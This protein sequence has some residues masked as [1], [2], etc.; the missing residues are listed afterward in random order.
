[1]DQEHP[2]S[3]LQES[4]GA[5]FPSTGTLEDRGRTWRKAS[6]EY[7]IGFVMESWGTDAANQTSAVVEMQR[8]LMVSIQAASDSAETQTAEVIKLT[9]ALKAYTIVLA[10]IGVVQIALIWLKG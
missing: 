5:A 6:D 3:K 1:M 4:K 9:R 8:R 10:M 2:F 7:L